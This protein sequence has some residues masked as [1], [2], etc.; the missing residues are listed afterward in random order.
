M[1]KLAPLS[2]IPSKTFQNDPR[3][4]QSKKGRRNEGQTK[5]ADSKSHRHPLNP[6]F[7]D[8]EESYGFSNPIL[9]ISNNI[10]ALRSGGR[11]R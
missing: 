10:T 3:K 6:Y 5:S 1:Q 4:K 7:T 8:R 2:F 9:Q 11:R